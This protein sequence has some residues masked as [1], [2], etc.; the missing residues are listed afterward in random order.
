M[1]K[2]WA[3]LFLALFAASC[4]AQDKLPSWDDNARKA[5]WTQNP[6]PDLW[7]K[8]ADALQAQLESSYKQNGSSVYS[9]SDFQNWLD[10]LEWIRL[11]LDSS[12]VL[13]NADSLKTFLALGQDDT[14]SHLFV[15]KLSP[16]DDKKQA[17]LLLLKLAQ[18]HPDD[19]HEYAALGVAYSLVFDQPFPRNWPHGQVRQSAVPIGNLDVVERF[20]FYVQANRNKKTD[21][22][23]TQVPVEDLKFLVDSELSIPELEYA[24]GKH[25]P[26][27]DF[28]QA[29]FS[30]TYDESRVKATNNMILVWDKSTYKLSDIETD[31]GIC[32]DQAYYAC[33]LGKGRG[34]PTIWFTGQGTDGGHAWFGYL[35]HDLKWVMDC[36]RYANQNYLKGYAID[37]QTWQQVKDTAIENLVKNGPRNTNYAPAKT[38]LAWARLHAGQ[39]SYQQLLDETRSIMPEL[40][41]TWQTEGDLMDASSTIS[42]QDKKTFYQAWIAQFQSNADLKVDGQTRLMALLKQAND[43]DAAGLQQDIILQNRSSGAD[44][45][46]KGSFSAISEKIDA[47]D[48]DGAKLAFE[49]AVR[50]FKDQGGGTFFN[51]VIEPYAETCA[52]HGQIKQA[53]DGLSFTKDRM[54]IDGQS[55]LG[56]EFARL[57]DELDILKKE[58]PEMDKWLGEI[59]DGNYEQAWNDGAKSLQGKTDLNKWIEYMNSTRKPFGKCTSRVLFNM[60]HLTRQL[61]SSSGMKIEGIF[62]FARYNSVFETKPQ[63]EETLIFQKESDGAWRPMEYYFKSQGLGQSAA[64]P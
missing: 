46:I 37:P 39:P 9:Q 28:A 49:N 11:G 59:D 51:D 36:G 26:Y 45:G 63:V 48:W 61:S 17:L 6:T 40:A 4:P 1:R 15:E 20:N 16:L 30:I 12:D 18:A 31:G 21:L 55:I 29:F 7:P 33:M 56:V 38:A 10:L 19:L 2:G 62:I 64:N 27:T 53:E 58:M 13:A 32:V 24:Q 52:Q 14:V 8:A 3:I 60:P 25:L 23:L 35:G 57:K 47:Q 43:P 54:S 41:E 22:D 50:D 42:L 5:W 44:L 34:I